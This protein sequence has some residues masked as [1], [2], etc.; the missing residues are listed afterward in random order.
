MVRQCCNTKQIYLIITD[1]LY[2][3]TGPGSKQS[4]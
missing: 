4:L 2:V 3:Y 1:Y